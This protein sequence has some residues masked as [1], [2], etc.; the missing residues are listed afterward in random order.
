MKWEK[1]YRWVIWNFLKAPLTG[2]VT[3]KIED[4][5]PTHMSHQTLEIS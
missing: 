3:W 5:N 4:I 1:M 2:I